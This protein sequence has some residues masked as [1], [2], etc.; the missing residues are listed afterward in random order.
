MV[1][2]IIGSYSHISMDWANPS[3]SIPKRAHFSYSNFSGSH[4]LE[5]PSEL[6]SGD[7]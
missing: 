4:L 7:A 1:D 6:N 2:G 5:K 3:I